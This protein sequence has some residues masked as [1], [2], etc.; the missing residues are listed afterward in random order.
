M[1]SNF[2]YDPVIPFTLQVN[3]VW[4]HSAQYMNP[5]MEELD[6]LQLLSPPPHT[7]TH[8]LN[9]NL[10]AVCMEIPF[11]RPKYTFNIYMKVCKLLPFLSKTYL[12]I[13]LRL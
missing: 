4:M 10:T 5:S 12:I 2:D 13:F 11:Q 1:M 9:V 7:H 8:T 3:F 6:K